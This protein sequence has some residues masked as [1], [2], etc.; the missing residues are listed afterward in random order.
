VRIVDAVTRTVPLPTQVVDSNAALTSSATD[1]LAIRAAQTDQLPEG[2]SSFDVLPDGGFVV[3][4]SLRER[5]VL[6][7]ERGKALKR[8]AVGTPPLTVTA[9][10]PNRFRFVSATEGTAATVDA[11]GCPN[12]SCARTVSARRGSRRLTSPS[13]KNAL[14]IS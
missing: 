5:L 8:I 10:G 1:A 13:C 11:D 12:A 3:A 6:F 2:P 14:A 7:D 9:Q 4:D